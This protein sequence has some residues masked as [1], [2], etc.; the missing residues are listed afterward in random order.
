MF[1]SLDEI[2][3]LT[4]FSY[5][6]KQIEWLIKRGWKFEINGRKEPKVAK[7][8]FEMKMGV[9]KTEELVTEGSQMK[10]NFQALNK[11]LRR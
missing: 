10:P 3:E 1:L 4:G 8:F 7:A 2:K 5:R 9:I 6:S 11:F